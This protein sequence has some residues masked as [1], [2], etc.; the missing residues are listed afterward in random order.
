MAYQEGQL[1]SLRPFLMEFRTLLALY[2]PLLNLPVD[3][4]W[5][6]PDRSKITQYE[7]AWSDVDFHIEKAAGL[8][9]GLVIFPKCLL[10][11][12]PR[13]MAVNDAAKITQQPRLAHFFSVFHWDCVERTACISLPAHDLDLLKTK[14]YM[15]MLFDTCQWEVIAEAIDLNPVSSRRMQE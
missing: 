13:Q 7:F 8:N 9:I 15:V 1:V 5:G 2:M 12:T 11:H 14:G 3:L 6:L 4:L 10:G